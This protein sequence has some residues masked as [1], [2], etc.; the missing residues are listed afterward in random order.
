MRTPALD[1]LTPQDRA[2]MHAVYAGIRA[3]HH[4][5]FEQALADTA[6]R[7]C[8]YRTAQASRTARQERAAAAAP[9]ALT[10]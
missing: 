5:T 2:D 9:F 1:Q 4:M 7:I 6:T 8:L 10:P 3:L